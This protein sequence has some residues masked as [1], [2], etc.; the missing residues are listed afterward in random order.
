MKKIINLN[1]KLFPIRAENWTGRYVILIHRFAYGQFRIQL[2][3]TLKPDYGDEGAGQI[4][5]EM[6]TYDGGK[7]AEVLAE[8]VT[9]DYPEK[10]CEAMAT[11][12][13]CEYPGGRIRLDNTPESRPETINQQPRK[14]KP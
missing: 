9:V 14:K 3:D 2:C 6:C 5:R 12:W 1:D 13:N 10:F 8:L 11:P 7:A 4:V